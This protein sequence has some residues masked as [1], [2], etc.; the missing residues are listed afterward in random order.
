[1]PNPE[2][3]GSGP[4]PI[5]SEAAGEI[6]D[7]AINQARGQEAIEA[8]AAAEA[9]EFEKNMAALQ[10]RREALEKM[11]AGDTSMYKAIL[12]EEEKAKLEAE[13]AAGAAT[14]AATETVMG[15]MKIKA[16]DPDTWTPDLETVARPGS[17]SDLT[18]EIPEPTPEQA[19]ETTPLKSEVENK[20]KKNNGFKKCLTRVTALALTAVAAI[21]ITLGANSSENKKAAS[22]IYGKAPIEMVNS[23]QTQEDTEAKDEAEAPE[24]A[25]LEKQHGI[26]DGYGMAGMWLDVDK[27]GKGFAFA[28]AAKVADE[29]DND[30]KEMI[31]YTGGNQVESMSDYIANMP[32]EIKPAEFKGLNLNDVNYKLENLTPDQ[33]DE[34]K[35]QFDALID[36]AEVSVETIEGEY[37]N[38]YMAY[39]IPGAAPGAK[40]VGSGDDYFKGEN[41]KITHENMKLVYCKTDEVKKNV[42]K[43]SWKWED[44][45]GNKMDA[46]MLYKII[47]VYNDA[48]EIVGYEG[49][50]QA[51]SKSE[52]PYEDTEIIPDPD[53][54]VYPEIT[55]IPNTIE[56]KEEHKDPKKPKPTTTPT[57]TNN[58]TPEVTPGPNNNPTPEVTPEVTP[59]VTPGVTPEVTPGV[60]PEVTPEVTPGP[61]NN[62][63]PEVTPEVTPE[64]KN[65]ERYVEMQNQINDIAEDIH[66]N[67]VVTQET[68]SE[69]VVNEM[70]RTDQPTGEEVFNGTDGSDLFVTNNAANPT[71]QIT[72]EETPTDNQA[73]AGSAPETTP[74]P[75]PEVIKV[76]DLAPENDP[77]QNLGGANYQ[78]PAETITETPAENQ[79]AGNA[80]EVIP[81][82]VTPNPEA[83][84]E[85]N[86][87]EIPIEEARNMSDQ[88]YDDIFAD[89]GL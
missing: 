86:A 50:I 38:A 35:A 79:G 52:K 81:P 43:L 55:P 10:A 36:Q 49:C 29:C 42:I 74:E 87:N 26:I 54:I 65:V 70:P 24:D 83:Q 60:T 88:D 31:K 20:A 9:S 62:P 37:H 23:T 58:P 77:S 32:D 8:K 75:T 7:R 64:A 30:V 61:N 48:G 33:F 47:P 68:P 51:L 2:N 63:T 69:V 25:E 27:P 45:A 18:P 73:A 46:S 72:L 4:A 6:S 19:A 34:I 59:G 66:S 13:A 56:K 89:L 14:E 71:P 82:A 44:E 16:V 22:F 80:A 39:S 84:A 3:L 57:P 53:P 67:K 85:A 41:I 5:N 1:M 21:G 78:A 40:G 11:R 15:T 17:E 76:E 28:N 12:E